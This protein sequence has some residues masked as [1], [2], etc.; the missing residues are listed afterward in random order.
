M[1]GI[2]IMDIHE[3]ELKN[4]PGI[5]MK[6]WSDDI[7]AHYMLSGARFDDQ[8]VL[9]DLMLKYSG[10][11]KQQENQADMDIH[12]H[13][14]CQHC[15]YSIYH[16]IEIRREA[17]FRHCRESCERKAKPG[18]EWEMNLVMRKGRIPKFQTF[19]WSM[20]KGQSPDSIIDV[21]FETIKDYDPGLFAAAQLCYIKIRRFDEEKPTDVS[22]TANEMLK[23]RCKNAGIPLGIN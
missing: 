9:L 6:T 3:L 7:Y 19:F 17:F 20:Q 11:C 18:D 12:C 16:E 1:K 21:I 10:A 23:E 5:C 13:L 4:R 2:R 15:D 8:K 22:S 14:D